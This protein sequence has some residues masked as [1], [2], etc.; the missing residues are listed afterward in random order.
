[1]DLVGAACIPWIASSYLDS[2]MRNN[3]VNVGTTILGSLCYYSLAYTLIQSS[4][5]LCG[6]IEH[7]IFV[8]NGNLRNF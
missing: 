1:M 3:L 8:V 2:S 6:Q 5:Q 7:S 4:G